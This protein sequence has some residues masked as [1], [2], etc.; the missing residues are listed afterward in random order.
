MIDEQAHENEGKDSIVVLIGS[1]AIR[2]NSRPYEYL[3][4]GLTVW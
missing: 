1:C 3:L 2:G 4:R